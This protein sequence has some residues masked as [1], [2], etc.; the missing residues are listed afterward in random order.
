MADIF[1]SFKTDDKPRVQPIVDAFRGLE[2][3]VFWSDDIPKGASSYQKHIAKEIDAAT[4]VVVVWTQAS[5]MSDP[6]AQECAQAKQDEKLF[7]VVLDHIRPIDFPMGLGYAAQKILLQGW[8][9]DQQNSEWVKLIKSNKDRC[10]ESPSVAQS[11]STRLDVVT[12]ADEAQRAFREFS[13]AIKRKSN[14]MEATIYDGKKWPVEVAYSQKSDVWF[15]LYAPK[16]EGGNRY[17]T[18]LGI[19]KPNARPIVTEHVVEINP[20]VEGENKN[21]GGVFLKDEAGNYYIG[22][23]GRLSQRSNQ[24]PFKEYLTTGWVEFSRKDGKGLAQLFGP[25]S[26]PNL[27]DE[28]AKFA[29]KVEDWRK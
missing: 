16:N 17:I 5:V 7:Q 27:V 28:L 6:V 8:T 2:L 21:V 4:V 1:V 25:F 22:H 10:Q 14:V 18:R 26:S 13:E 3:K 15:W 12:S 20:P 19:G 24:Q 9:G 23:T 29:R 11:S